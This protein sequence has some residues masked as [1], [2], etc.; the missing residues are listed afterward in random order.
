MQNRGDMAWP[1]TSIKLDFSVLG[2]GRAVS[3]VR[4]STIMTSCY[5]GYEHLMDKT[6]TENRIDANLSW[7]SIVGCWYWK[8][9]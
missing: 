9:S 5:D 8:R 3:V 6:A 1:E 4:T 7:I 2:I